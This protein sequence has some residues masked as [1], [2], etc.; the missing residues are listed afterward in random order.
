MHSVHGWKLAS[1][2]GAFGVAMALGACSS[3]AGGGSGDVGTCAANATEDVAA[4]QQLVASGCNG[5]HSFEAS[6]IT[7]SNAP[8]IMS[9]IEDGSMP[10]SGPFDATQT[11]QVRTYLAC[12]LDPYTG[13][14]GAG[15]GTGGGGGG[16][17]GTQ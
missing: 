11:E 16:T 10:P 9:R 5:C 1:I 15:G 6:N 14:G 7:N 17:V 3:S 12:T 13:G 4:G 8:G 2:A